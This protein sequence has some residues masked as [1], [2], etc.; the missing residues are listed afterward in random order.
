MCICTF[1]FLRYL[2]FPCRHVLVVYKTT[3]DVEDFRTGSCGN[4]QSLL[5]AVF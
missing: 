5:E 2:S 1:L 4:V 3:S